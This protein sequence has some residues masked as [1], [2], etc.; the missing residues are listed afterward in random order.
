MICLNVADFR[1]AILQYY[2]LSNLHWHNSS[3][4]S[5]PLDI[6]W[7]VVYEIPLKKWHLFWHWSI[8]SLW[9]ALWG[10]LS[11]K[12]NK[13][14][15]SGKP[16]SL[17]REHWQFSPVAVPSSFWLVKSN[18]SVSYCNVVC[19]MHWIFQCCHAIQPSQK[20][21]G[22]QLLRLVGLVCTVTFRK[23]RIWYTVLTVQKLLTF[24]FYTINLRITCVDFFLFCTL[25]HEVTS[26]S[27]R[28][29]L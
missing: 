11:E 7:W 15:T 6:M 19:F 22:N 14:I 5:V 29:E 17:A 24:W 28:H 1:Q 27:T 9:S 26:S 4:V 3:S 25:M 23:H 20:C 12:N 16:V 13:F 18:V 8:F 2:C 10:A 21:T